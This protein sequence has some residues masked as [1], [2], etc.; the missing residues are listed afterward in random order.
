MIMRNNLGI[1]LPVASLPGRHGIGD[2]GESSIRFIDWLSENHYAYWQILPLNPLG[3]G[4]SP[5]M[6]TC[7]NAF[8]YRYISLDEL[9]K[10]GLIKKVKPFKE[11]A[12]EV[13]YYE[14]GNFKSEV[15]WKAYLAYRKTNM[16][17]MKEFRKANPWVNHFATF[18]V[19]KNLNGQRAWNE[20]EKWQITYFETHKL[21]PRRYKMEVE[22]SIFVQYIAAKQWKKVLE[23]ARSK[24]VKL[25]AD[26]PFYCGFDSIEV[27]LHQ[28]QFLLQD[29]KQTHEGGVPPDAFSDIGQLWGS[30]IY[31]FDKMK[32]DNYSLLVNRTGFLATICDYL[33]LDHFRAFDTYYVI[34]A[35]MPDAKIGE[36]K[37]GPRTDF[38][39]ALYKAYPDINL[40]AEDLGDLFP[41]VLELRDHYNFPGMYIVEFT[42][43]DVNAYPNNNLIVYP[44]TH[45]NETIAGWLKNL[46]RHNIDFLKWKFNEGDESKLFDRMFEYVLSLPSLMT[47]LPLQDLLRLDNSARLNSPGTVGY[48]NF[49][50]KM[51]SFDM[52]DD[53]TF[54]VS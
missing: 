52:L 40:I 53:I 17:G 14:V 1:L 33:R 28:D 31:N 9:V 6:S 13:D 26:M 42:V 3:P 34:P 15:L 4:Y 22:F 16:K 24:N 51:T 5:Y 11:D 27:W 41:S 50:W 43:F 46:P 45:D 19:F 30:P 29:Y 18:E 37:I 39:D 32:E 38:F 25:I 23:Y 21:P 49:V 12:S 7:S 2:F 48:P 54:K 35:G 47:I 44:G 36:W 10:E 8:D 20:W